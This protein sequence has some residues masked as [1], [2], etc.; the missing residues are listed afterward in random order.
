MSSD[1]THSA[2]LKP[3]GFRTSDARCE[4]E[5]EPDLACLARSHFEECAANAEGCAKFVGDDLAL[6]A[7]TIV[8][9][10][11]NDGKVLIGSDADSVCAAQRLSALLSDKFECPRLGLPAFDL[12][13]GQAAVAAI[14]Q[15]E[16][17]E[18]TLAKQV[19]SLGNANDALI[20]LGCDPDAPILAQA[21]EAA[22]RRAMSVIALLGQGSGDIAQRLADRDILIDVGCGRPA[23]AL[24]MQL[25]S[26]HALCG[27][28]DKLLTGMG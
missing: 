14:A 26:I 5:S 6:C 24:E 12:S 10:F 13:S 1:D 2:A 16:G 21:V 23:R 9:T 27:C 8:E 22:H 3:G 17:W 4:R 28:V 19:G 15:S 18:Q 11:F 25:A 7:Q 20:L